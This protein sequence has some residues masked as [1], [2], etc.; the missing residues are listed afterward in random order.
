[1]RLQSAEPAPAPGP[2]RWRQWARR[3]LAAA[4]PRR[5]LLVSGPPGRAEVCL[6]FDDGPDPE[7][8]PR[9][10][11]ALRDH[12]ARATFFV[13]GSR[14]ERYPDLVRRAAAEGHAV[15]GH[16][17]HHGTPEETSARQ[18]AE[19]ARRT[20]RLV[21]GLLGRPPT[22][23]RPPHG[24]LTAAKLWALWR[25]GQTIVLWNVDPKDFLCRSPS[26]LAERIA[27]CPPRAGDVVLLHD[28]RPHTAGALPSLI[29]DVRSAGLTFT[30]PDRWL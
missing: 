24:K 13:V 14:A 4:L 22:V 29:R 18:L 19:E 27:Q 11:D 25:A 21:G 23:F 1:M 28:N 10:L 5:R 17:Y 12:G 2:I 9:V 30:T 6:T 15:G 26:E 20:S 16:S 7:H 3:W 8:T